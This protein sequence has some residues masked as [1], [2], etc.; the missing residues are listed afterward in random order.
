MTA[1]HAARLDGTEPSAS[2]Q[3]RRS[4]AV[5]TAGAVS[6]VAG[7][8]AA[9][10][11][12]PTGWDHGSWVAAFLVL[13]AGVT[14]IGLG[15]GQALL[16]SKPTSIVFTATWCSLWN[17]GCLLVIVGTLLASP[18][19]VS[20]GGGLMAVG[21]VMST[22]AARGPSRWPVVGLVYRAILVVVAVSVPIGV[23]LAWTRH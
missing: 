6:V 2:Q 7:G 15:A 18:V 23:A 14:Q 16:A 20:C 11:T 22:H 9:A 8:L 4:A 13:V 10:V 5:F 17:G 3:W 1:P 19:V 12:G 21:L